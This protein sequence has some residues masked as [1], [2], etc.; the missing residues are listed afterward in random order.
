MDTNPSL[1][2]SNAIQL[3]YCWN[4]FRTLCILVRLVQVK[5]LS[6]FNRYIC[7]DNHSFQNLYF[8]LKPEVRL[9]V[10]F[11]K[12]YFWYIC[13]PMVVTPGKATTWI[14]SQ[15]CLSDSE[16]LLFTSC[17]DPDTSWNSI[18]KDSGRISVEISSYLSLGQR[19][20]CQDL[21]GSKFSSCW[22]NSPQLIWSHISWNTLH[23]IK[24]S[25]LLL[26]HIGQ[27]VSF[28]FTCNY[29]KWFCY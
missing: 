28:D 13:I 4:N 22:T 7:T 25:H 23:G 3:V 2:S 19:N 11:T 24:T 16:L 17:M 20:L 18:C 26:H 9:E 21:A 6:I 1:C 29:S 5:K 15:H 12:R 14:K 27:R 8:R 10:G